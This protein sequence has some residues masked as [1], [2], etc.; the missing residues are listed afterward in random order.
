MGIV[1]PFQIL[2]CGTPLFPQP[3]PFFQPGDQ[4]GTQISI[5]SV[6]GSGLFYSFGNS[7]WMPLAII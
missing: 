7:P 1:L 2:A 6:Y 4:N 3:A 5:C